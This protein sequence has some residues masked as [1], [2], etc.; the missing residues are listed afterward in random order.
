MPEAYNIVVASCNS[1]TC[2]NKACLCHFFP[3]SM[4]LSVFSLAEQTVSSVSLFFSLCLLCPNPT[5]LTSLKQA[6]HPL[7]TWVRTPAWVIWWE[8]RRNIGKMKDSPSHLGSCEWIFF[9][10]LNTFCTGILFSFNEEVY[11]CTD[12]KTSRCV[13]EDKITKTQLTEADALKLNDVYSY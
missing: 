8:K 11:C 1:V 2:C 5:V 7:E 4:S 12:I 3:L 9:L 10:P 6:T 13:M